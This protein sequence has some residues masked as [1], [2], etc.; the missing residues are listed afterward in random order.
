MANVDDLLAQAQ[1][2]S[3][4]IAAGLVDLLRRFAGERLRVSREALDRHERQV[5]AARLL[6]ESRDRAAVVETLARR[7][8]VSRRTA[9]RDLAAALDARRP[10]MAPR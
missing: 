10:P 5:D 3:P 6:A 8:H 4:D 1:A 2:V 9:R 7:W